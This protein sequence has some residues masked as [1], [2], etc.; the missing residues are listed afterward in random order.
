[1]G[2]A[3]TVKKNVYGLA[4]V[5]L[6]LLSTV[7]GRVLVDTVNAEA[8]SAKENTWTTKTPIPISRVAMTA[9]VVDGKIYVFCYRAVYEYNPI[10]DNWTNK[11]TIPVQTSYPALAVCGTKIYVIGGY[12]ASENQVY[13]TLTDTWE[14]KKPMPMNDFVPKA[15]AVD[16]TIYVI[17]SSNTYCYNIA[18]DSWSNKTKMP[19]E[20]TGI[21][22]SAILNDKIYFFSTKQPQI[23]DPKTDS[24]S[25]GALMPQPIDYPT[26]SATTGVMAPKKIYVFGG[27]RSSMFGGAIATTQVYDPET[28]SWV[29]GAPMLTERGAATSAAVN[30]LIYVIGGDSGIHTCFDQNEQYTPFGYGTPDPS[31]VPPTAEPKPT[32]HPSNYDDNTI[33]EPEPFP[34]ALV[35]AASGASIAIIGG[36]LLVYFKKRK[37]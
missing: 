15:I 24:W 12:N 5:L 8:E 35:I 30:D 23:Y 33:T 3:V 26:A 17:T 4:F 10:T 25:L 37:R 28:D 14:V 18:N 22:A 20:V 21:P 36:G 7:T 19:Y 6:L 2:V 1:L 27:M 13:D 34:T 32:P 16:G 31:Y 11:T 29:L 9:A